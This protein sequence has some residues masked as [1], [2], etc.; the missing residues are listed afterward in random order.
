MSNWKTTT[1]IPRKGTAEKAEGDRLRTLSAEQLR[2]LL[3]DNQAAAHREPETA[4][5]RLK[6]VRAIN[7]ECR[8][9]IAKAKRVHS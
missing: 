3:L 9:R 6:L 2:Q 1:R 5:A 8:R 7:E 4:R